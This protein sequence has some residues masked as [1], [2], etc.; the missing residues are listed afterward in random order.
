MKNVHIVYSW[1]HDDLPGVLAK[2][3]QGTVQHENDKS[4]ND[5]AKYKDY[6][7][8]VSYITVEQET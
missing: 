7:R 1:P 2:M 3:K 4:Q 8:K 6:S 5:K